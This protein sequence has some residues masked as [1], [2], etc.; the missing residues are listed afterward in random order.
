MTTAGMSKLNLGKIISDRSVPIK[1]A[2]LSNE[3]GFAG[4]NSTDK[5]KYRVKV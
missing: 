4:M 3:R 2:F 1:C 5:R